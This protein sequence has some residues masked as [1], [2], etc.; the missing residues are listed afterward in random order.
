ML[1]KKMW[2]FVFTKSVHGSHIAF[3]VNIEYPNYSHNE[4]HRHAPTYCKQ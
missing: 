3:D 4:D 1:F 2:F